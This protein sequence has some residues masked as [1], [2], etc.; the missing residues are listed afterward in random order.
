M[1]IKILIR[2]LIGWILIQYVPS[3]LKLKGMIRTIVQVIGVVI[4]LSALLQLG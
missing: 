4:L 3:W 2:V 1:I